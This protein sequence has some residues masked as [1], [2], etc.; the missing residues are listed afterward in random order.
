MLSGASVRY[1]FY[2][3][4]GVTAEEL[5]RIVFS[6]LGDVLAG[7]AGA[8]RHQPG[9]AARCREHATCLPR[10]AGARRPGGCCCA[11]RRR[12]SLRPPP[13]REPIRLWRLRAAAAA[14]RRSPS[15]QLLLSSLDWALAGAVLYVL[16]PAGRRAVPGVSRRVPRRDAPR[17]WP[18]TCP[19]AWACSRGCWSLLLKPYLRPGGCCR[20]CSSTARCITCCRSLVALIGLVADELR[21]RRGAGGSASAAVLGWLTEQLTPRVLA[22][23]TFLARRRAAVLGCDAGRAP[24]GWSCSSR[25]APAR[26][27]RGLA[28]HRQRRRRRA[29]AAVAGPGAP[30]R[31]GVLPDGRRDRRRHRRVAAQGRSTTRKRCCWRAC[32]WCWSRD[33]PAFDRRAAFFETRFSPVWMA[34]VVGARRR[35]DLARRC[36][37]SS[38]SSTRSELWWQFELRGEASRFLRASVGAAVVVLLFG[39]ARLVRPAPHEVVPPAP[40]R[41]WTML[42]RIIAAQ[43]TTV[44]EPGVPARQGADV[45]RR[46]HAA[47]SCTAVQGRTWVAMGDPV[48][49]DDACSDLIR[50]FLE[51]VRRLRRRAGVLRGGHGRTCTAMPTSG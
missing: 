7:A 1:R 41:T 2:T 12:T 3:R 47:S 33:A 43:P 13:A 38:T 27:D 49:P 5:S 8:R 15:T 51:R 22:V 39:F 24:D 34:A 37:R 30:P 28:F 11:A 45:Q 10:R 14:A 31:R 19:A 36:S 20:R 17:A 18:A 9:A 29:A 4:W 48:G 16:L 44:A 21:Q 46:A 40:T 25:C 23:F 32:W 50:R 6:L 26:R 42:E 35:V